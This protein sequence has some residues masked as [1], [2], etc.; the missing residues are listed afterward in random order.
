MENPD[1]HG[2]EGLRALMPS[3][4]RGNPVSLEGKKTTQEPLSHWTT[5]DLS[6]S[7]TFFSDIHL[8]ISTNR[9]T[10][11]QRWEKRMQIRR[12]SLWSSHVARKTE[13][14]TDDMVMNPGKK[15]SNLGY[16]FN[17]HPRVCEPPKEQSSGSHHTN[18]QTVEPRI[19]TRY[20]ETISKPAAIIDP[21]RGLIHAR[22]HFNPL[23]CLHLFIYSGS[24]N[25]HRGLIAL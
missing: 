13:A 24:K 6:D 4:L 5:P 2:E 3:Q 16:H 9:H 25:I 18:S 12:G 22:T 10:E 1:P 11:R 23:C 7:G 8:S 17:K 19:Y 14:Q 15:S 21:G 20:L